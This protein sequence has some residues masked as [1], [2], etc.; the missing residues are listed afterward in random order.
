M[1]WERIRPNNYYTEPVE[2]IY[3]L[4]L[5]DT[6]EYDKLY[7]NQNNFNHSCWL[8]FDAKHRMGFE[9][10]EDFYDINTNK[11]VI[12]LWFFKERSDRKLSHVSIAGKKLGYHPNAFL[13]TTS[14][15]IEFI[16]GKSRY[17]R[18]PFLQLDMTLKT[19]SE[20]VNQFQK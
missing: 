20:I 19:Y 18:N 14:K 9:L 4:T 1:N 6:K 13:I 2:Y 5:F 12:C 10:K 16:P 15:D 8:D 7:E 3:A 11:E 17:I